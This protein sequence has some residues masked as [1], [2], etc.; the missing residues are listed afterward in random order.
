[1]RA[2]RCRAGLAVVAC[3]LLGLRLSLSL[4]SGDCDGDGDVDHLDFEDLMVC[5]N[6]PERLPAPECV[7]HSDFD[8]DGDCDLADYA[9]FQVDFDATGVEAPLPAKSIT[10]D[11]ILIHDPASDQYDANCTAAECHGDRRQ[12]LALDGVT[13]AAHRLMVIFGEG[14]DRCARCHGPGAD[15]MNGSAANLREQVDME[16]VGC[17][18]CHGPINED[19]QWYMR[20]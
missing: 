9:V 14:D 17:T 13:P 3:V 8:Q 19:H 1:M 4:A 16:T 7:C 15:L 10:F 6:G 5:L 11:L 18:W 2:S 12:E 20:P